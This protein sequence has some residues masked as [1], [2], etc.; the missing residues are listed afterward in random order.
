MP[1]APEHISLDPRHAAVRVRISED[2]LHKRASKSTFPVL[3]TIHPPLVSSSGKESGNCPAENQGPDLFPGQSVL[4]RKFVITRGL[5]CQSCLEEAVSKSLGVALLDCIDMRRK[6]GAEL[7]KD[8]IKRLAAMEKITASIEKGAPRAINRSLARTRKRLNQLL[9]DTDMDE[10]R[11][12][13][14]AAIMIDRT[15][16]SEELVRLKSHLHRFR[17]VLKKGGEISKKL[18]FLLQ[19]IHREATTMGNKAVDSRIIQHCLAI[20]EGAEKIREQV[21]NIE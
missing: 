9:G 1:L 7:F 16:F 4:L 17:V 11:W 19:E 20:K 13:I 21:L 10:N 3:G 8:I 18:T 12:V 5:A 15:D 14:E 6:E 2:Q